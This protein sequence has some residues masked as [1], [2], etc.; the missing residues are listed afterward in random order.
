MDCR[1][2]VCLCFYLLQNHRLYVPPLT[3]LEGCICQDTGI[4][5]QVLQLG[6]DGLRNG[7]NAFPRIR[8][9]AWLGQHNLVWMSSLQGI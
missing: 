7:I 1:L 2:S 4:R 8:L 9:Q 5:K 6:E 3:T